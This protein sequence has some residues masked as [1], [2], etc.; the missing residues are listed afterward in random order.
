MKPSLSVNERLDRLGAELLKSSTLRDDEIE[1]IADGRD[2]FSAVRARI[3]ADRVA[4]TNVVG[5]FTFFQR[6]AIVSTAVAVIAIAVFATLMAARKVDQQVVNKRVPAVDKK[7]PPKAD[8]PPDQ[9]FVRD[10]RGPEPER[11]SEPRFEKAGY[12][13]VTQPRRMPLRQQPQY[14]E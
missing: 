8:L 13:P 10:V 5:P 9:D 12:R 14:Q 1:S 7:V 3:I 11:D 4:E 6:A 2:L